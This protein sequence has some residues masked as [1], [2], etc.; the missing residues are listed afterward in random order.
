MI[1]ICLNKIFII[2][3]LTIIFAGS[4][5]ASQVDDLMRQG[6]NYYQQKEYGKAITSYQKLTDQGYEGVSLFYNLGNSYYREGKLGFAILNYEKA[7]KISPDDDDV[8]HNLAIANAKTVDKIDMLPKFFLFQWWES[9][10]ALFTVKGWTYL[11]Y[12]FYILVLITAGLYFIGKQSKVQRYSFLGGLS[13]LMLLILSVILLIVNL[14]RELNI[15]QGIIIKPV[16]SVKLS[17]DSNS[18]DAFVIH[19]GLK[20]QIEDNVDNWVKIRLHD[21]KI[22]WLPEQDLRA[23]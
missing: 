13:L 6:N 4:L 5:F 11:A 10:L 14:N 22:G 3:S 7:L 16:I 19:E 18:N 21:G 23:I 8:R 2:F 15:K 20:V 1:K 17:P 12:I 9:L